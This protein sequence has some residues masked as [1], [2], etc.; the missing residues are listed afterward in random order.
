[1]LARLFT[2]SLYGIEAPPVDVDIFPGAMPRTILVSILSSVC[3]DRT[4]WRSGDVYS[5]LVAIGMD[6]D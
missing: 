3:R 4:P 2:Y 6:R 5:V 1:M